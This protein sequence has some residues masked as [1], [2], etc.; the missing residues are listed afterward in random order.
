MSFEVRP[1]NLGRES[2]NLPDG[3]MACQSPLCPDSDRT[4]CDAPND[5]LCHWPTLRIFCSQSLIAW[6]DPARDDFGYASHHRLYQHYPSEANVNTCARYPEV[7]GPS[8]LVPA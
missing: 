3:R 8:L 2:I 4:Y 6:R 1:S 5:A 7:F